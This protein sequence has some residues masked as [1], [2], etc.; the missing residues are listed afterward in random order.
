MKMAV[1]DVEQQ[2]SK[3]KNQ[4]L[5]WVISDTRHSETT[6]VKSGFSLLNLSSF[7]FSWKDLKT[8]YK[9][10]INMVTAAYLPSC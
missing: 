2:T 7:A 1:S 4:V 9:C 3:M 6:E 10:Q 5:T 8:Y